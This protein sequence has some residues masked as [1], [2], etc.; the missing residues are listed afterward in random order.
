MSKNIFIAILIATTSIC[1]TFSTMLAVKYF[2]TDK[3]PQAQPQQAVSLPVSPITLPIP[4]IEPLNMDSL[5]EEKIIEE[6][7]KHLEI[8][9][10]LA[11]QLETTKQN[12]LLLTSDQKKL[13]Q[14][15]KN[16]KQSQDQNIQKIS[17]LETD[18]A[19]LLNKYNNL[20][21]A[22]NSLHE[23]VGLIIHKIKNPPQQIPFI[24]PIKPKSSNS[25]TVEI[26]G[27]TYIPSK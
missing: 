26:Q 1:A 22:H 16:F 10:E 21:L 5:L 7:S 4:Q 24:Q 2:E 11:T 12:I 6:Q 25:N 17:D 13:L 3:T 15:L 19:N 27:E 8:I 23:Q 20:V 18:R 14:I 9:A